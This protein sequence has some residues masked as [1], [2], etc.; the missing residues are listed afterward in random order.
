MSWCNKEIGGVGTDEKLII[1]FMWP[2]SILRDSC[3]VTIA[4]N[5]FACQILSTKSS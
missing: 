1:M 2:N 5:K 4:G 3:P